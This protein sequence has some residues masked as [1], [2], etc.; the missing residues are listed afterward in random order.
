MILVECAVFFFFF[1]LGGGDM[2]AQ[3]EGKREKEI[4]TSDPQLIELP[5]T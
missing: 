1:F 3:R 4:R 5:E 2:F